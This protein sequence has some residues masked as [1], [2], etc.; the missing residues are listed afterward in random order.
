[1]PRTPLT[2]E[3]AAVR[4][5]RVSA[6]QARI[7]RTLTD[8]FIDVP[9]NRSAGQEWVLVAVAHT[10]G[11]A[12]CQLC[13]HNPIRRLFF[14]KSVSSG[15]ELMIGSECA[16]NYVRV[17]LVDAYL[18]SLVREQ[19]T[20]RVAAQR[21]ERNRAY[22][23]RRAARQAAAAT[24]GAA[25]RAANADVIA[26][27]ATR[28]GGSDRFL[29]SLAAQVAQPG[30]WLTERQTAAAR[31]NMER[32]AAPAAAPAQDD[33]AGPDDAATIFNGVYTIDMG[34]R[35]LTYKIHT[36][37][38]GPLQGKRIVKR[39]QQYGEFQGFGFLNRQGG[40][41]LWR[42]F[43]DDRQA[44]Y[45]VWAEKLLEILSTEACRTYLA[46]GNGA[47]CHTD[48]PDQTRIS[49][50]RSCRR[51]NRALT[52]PTSIGRGIGPECEA[53]LAGDHETVVADARATAPAR[54]AFGRARAVRAAARPTARPVATQGALALSEIVSEEVQ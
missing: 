9:E 42:R 23:E 4:R 19:N 1:M 21:A 24:G 29:A 35:H 40:L 16:R 38:S 22:E 49:L 34:G 41:S 33:T 39:Q 37:L 44:T 54:S 26:F 18:N 7:E 43:N 36:V 46:A 11:H 50:S 28:A 52:T 48:G 27:L 6:Y 5:T 2:P 31:T 25:W 17:N 30:G 13:G 51:C 8:I 15:R 32:A 45:V 53:R 20:R 14:I 3:E 10:R 47:Y 12:T